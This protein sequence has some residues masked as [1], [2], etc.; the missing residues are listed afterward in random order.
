MSAWQVFE[1]SILRC[2]IFFRTPMR[3]GYI[4]Y[5]CTFADPAGVLWP[6]QVIVIVTNKLL[7]W[8]VHLCPRN[9]RGIVLNF[10]FFKLSLQLLVPV[11]W[12]EWHQWIL[13]IWYYIL[14]Y[15]FGKWADCEFFSYNCFWVNLLPRFNF[16]RL[17][18]YISLQ[19]CDVQKIFLF[20]CWKLLV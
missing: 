18:S 17:T 16:H 1:P 20:L 13:C 8:P 4:N 10:W 14:W 9:R 7:R 5:H 12:W 15:S 19:L 11:W 3:I 2:H 6:W